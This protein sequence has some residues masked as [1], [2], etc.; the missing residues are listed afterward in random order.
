MITLILIFVLATILLKTE[1]ID[2]KYVLIVYM[3]LMVTLMTCMKNNPDYNVYREVFEGAYR[4]F[5]DAYGYMSVELL[6][7]KLNLSYG[8]FRLSLA[9]FCASVFAL[10]YRY[11]QDI[12]YSFFIYLLFVVY[13]DVTQIRFAVALF[14]F[15]LGLLF[16]LQ[17][18]SMV[19]VLLCFGSA[20][21]FHSTLVAPI[22]IV[23]YLL[24]V[25][26]KQIHNILIR[27]GIFAL[28]ISVLILFFGGNALTMFEEYKFHPEYN[29]SWF[30][31]LI[32]KIYYYKRTEISIKSLL[33][34][35]VVYF[36]QMGALWFGGVNKILDVK[37]YSVSVT[38][39]FE[40]SVLFRLTILGGIFIPCT[41]YIEEFS[42]IIRLF[43]VVM[44]LLFTIVS[45]E[46]VVE[47]RK[48]IFGS[49]VL[50][51]IGLMLGWYF[52]GVNPDLWW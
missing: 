16:V 32:V 24:L 41:L 30:E 3:L 17:K 38:K 11:N 10:W 49:M 12:V 39:K 19:W 50:V 22:V 6:F 14:L 43:C 8:F 35:S 21:S 48:M 47:K 4:P 36:V 5:A 46:L 34:W 29:R 51:N 20:I 23:V 18:K 26:R 42:R 31:W 1:V 7:K 33:I 45:S 44:A 52:R 13:Y 40:V 15:L 9:I 2:R 27:E 37:N 28:L 25:E